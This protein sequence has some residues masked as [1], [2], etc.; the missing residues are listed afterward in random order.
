[1]QIRRPRE[2]HGGSSP[3]VLGRA[4]VAD[5]E[6]PH[7]IVRTVTG[8]TNCSQP[9]LPLGNVVRHFFRVTFVLGSPGR[10]CIPTLYRRTS[11][12]L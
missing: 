7:N 3:P 5:T 10:G 2:G 11:A 8:S 1:M 4:L 12:T 9:S 6:R